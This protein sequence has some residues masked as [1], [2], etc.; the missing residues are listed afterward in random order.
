MLDLQPRVHLQKKE[1]LVLPS[2]ELNRAGGIIV[3]GAGEGHGLLAH[4]APRRLVEQRRGR[5][6]DDLLVA[7]LN[8]TFALA[9]I[10]H[11]AMLVAEHLDFDMARVDDEFFDEHAVVAKR[12]HGFG[13]RARKTLFNFAARLRNPHALAAAAG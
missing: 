9:E 10:N 8:G 6:L 2:D 1:T 13:F 11:I 5:F 12:R 7:A 4:L 3:D